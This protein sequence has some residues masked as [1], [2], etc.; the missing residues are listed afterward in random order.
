VIIFLIRALVVV[1]LGFALFTFVDFAT[2]ARLQWW[3]YSF[4]WA[5]LFLTGSIVGG[6][7]SL[8]SNHSV[9]SSS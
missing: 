3:N 8:R 1:G 7:L 4:M 5:I 9:R 2:A 6:L